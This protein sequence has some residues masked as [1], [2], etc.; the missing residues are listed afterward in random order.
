MTRFHKACNGELYVANMWVIGSNTGT[1]FVFCRT[2]GFQKIW[3]PD[4][5][6]LSQILDIEIEHQLF[7]SKQ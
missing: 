1:P 4:S 5:P 7:A 3:W 6:A 2:C